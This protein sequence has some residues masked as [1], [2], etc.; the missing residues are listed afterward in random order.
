[1]CDRSSGPGDGPEIAV[2][3]KSG[4]AE[5]QWIRWSEPNCQWLGLKSKAGQR[6]QAGPCRSIFGYTV[7]RRGTC[8]VPV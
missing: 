7:Q 2:E 4:S 5:I 8:S 6:R 3:L 1:M